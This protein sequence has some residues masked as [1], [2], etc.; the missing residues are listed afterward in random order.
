[1]ESHGQPANGTK[2]SENLQRLDVRC[3]VLLVG[4]TE[5]GLIDHATSKGAAG[6]DHG[7]AHTSQLEHR[8]IC[9]D[10][11]GEQYL[12]EPIDTSFPPPRKSLWR[13]QSALVK[14]SRAQDHRIHRVI[15]DTGSDHS[16]ITLAEAKRL[17]LIPIVTMKKLALVDGSFLEAVSYVI[18]RLCL[19]EIGL[20]EVRVNALIL[21][22]LP[23]G[24]ALLI[25]HTEI[26]NHN[27]TARIAERQSGWEQ[28]NGPAFAVD[29][30][31]SHYLACALFTSRS[32]EQ[33]EDD[34]KQL[35][36]LEVEAAHV[37]AIRENSMANMATV[38]S[39]SSSARSSTES[40]CPETC[41][42]GSQDTDLTTPSVTPK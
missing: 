36:P 38:P 37:L 3:S 39:S 26:M 35:E 11:M 5:G 1:M 41:E 17:G 19:L 34:E 29:P 23:R 30:E 9:H 15:I 25:G 4:A 8:E 42:E 14:D 33:R 28:T 6:V 18:L 2:E 24:H 21:P 27:I 10:T 7:T 12:S 16:A 31:P 32:S 20:G 13:H 40:S 22:R